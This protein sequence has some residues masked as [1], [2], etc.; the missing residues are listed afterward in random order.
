MGNTKNKII[1]L[2][3]ESI[4]VLEFLAEEEGRSVKN[5]MERVLTGHANDHEGRYKGTIKS[6]KPSKK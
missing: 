5:Y 3:K 2:H 1:T 6:N 4:K